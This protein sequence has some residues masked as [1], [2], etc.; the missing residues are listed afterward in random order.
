M[1]HPARAFLDSGS[2][3]NFIT[4]TLDNKLQ[5]QRKRQHFEES[6]IGDVT[7]KLQFSVSMTIRSHLSADE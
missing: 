5:L 3:I 6:G 7:A 1:F 4:D 2:E